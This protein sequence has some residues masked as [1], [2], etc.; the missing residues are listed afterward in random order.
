MFSP[1]IRRSNVSSR[2]ERNQGHT[3]LHSPI[4]PLSENR[5]SFLQNSVP[6][7]PSTGTPAPWAPRLS[8]LARIPPVNRSETGDEADP[9][10]P[11]YVGEFPQVIRDE[12]AS[13]LQKRVPDDA[14]ISGG[15]EKGTS[16]AWI[17]IGNRLFIW[18]YLSPTASMKCVVLEIPL[19]ALEN[20]DIN[21]TDR[22]C[23]L[24]CVV[25]W[26]S[27]SRRTKKVAKHC[28]S[29]GV[30]LCNQ[31][32]R[33]IIYWPEVY[34]EGRTAPVTSFASSEELEVTS[35]HENGKATP[36]KQRQRIR[37]GNNS[38]GWSS[39]NSLMASALP[40]SQHSCVALACCSNGEL[41]QFHCSPT[42][43]HRKKIYEDKLTLP[44]Q[45]SDGGQILW[46]KGYPRSLIWRFSHVSTEGSNREFFLLTDREIQCF[47]IDM[48]L[49]IR[50]SKLWSHE[51]IGTDGDAGIRK[52]LAGQKRIWPLDLQVD[53]HGKVITILVATFCKDRVSGS[54]YTQ[55]SLL[56]MQYKSGVSMEPAHERIL[57][58]KAPI[59]V[60][61]PKARVEDEDFLFS[62]RLRIGGK[63][64][65]SA[66]IL[67]GD[68]TATVA[69]YYRNSTHLY[70]F[71]LPY[72][73]GKVLDASVLLSSDDGEE[74]PWVVL[75]EKAGIW[76]IPEK[77]VVLGGVEPPERSLS[78]KGSSNER[79]AQEETR[80]LTFLGNIAPR[81]ASSEA[82]DAGE[83]QTGAFTG[84]VRR[85]GPD[86]ESE[87]LLSHLFHDFLSSG[88]VD[89]SL[90]KLKSSGAFERDGETS[91]FARM[92]KSIVDTLAK[93]WTTTRGAEIL[94]MAV[95]STQLMDKQQKHKA[96]LQFLALSK[97][98][99]ELCSRQRY[100]LRIILEHGEK[101]AGMIQLRELQNVIG[102]KRSTGV[103]S[104]HPSAER[105]AL[106]DLIQLVGE[107]ARRNTV[108]LMDRDNAEVFYSKVSDLE[109]V[110]YCLDRHLDYVIS[111]EQPLWIQIQRACELSNAC[112]T[113]VREAM[114]YRNENNLWYPPP[115]GLT[116]WYCQPVVR[117]G[118][119][120]IASFML[121]LLNETSGVEL[122]V[123]SDLYTHLEVL[124]EVLLETY[125][126]AVTAKVERGEEHKGL[127]DEFWSRRDTL[128]DSL[129]Q[130]VQDFVDG[131]HQD[132]NRGFEEQKE[133]I[134]RKL[135]LHLLSI[136][137]QHECY[138]TLWR[139]CCDLNDAALLRNLMHESMGPNGG[140]SYFVFKELYE[141]RQV[142]K[143]L[144]LGE[145][146][147]EEL[148]IFLR[149]HQELLWLHEVFLNQ[150]SSASEILHVLALSC[151]QNS[152]SASEEQADLDSIDFKPKL[153]DRK[154]L[155]NLSK[156][157]AWA[158]TGKDADSETKLKRIEA[159]RKILKLQ[160]EIML[161]LPTDEEKQYVERQLLHPEDLIKLCLKG[162]NAKL[163]LCAFD[164]FAWTGSSFRKTHRNLM[165]ECWKNA[166]DQDDWSQIYQA[167]IAQGWS[168][169]ETLQNLRE[170]MLFL[171]SSRCYG[172]N[173]E[174]F[175]EGFAEVMLLRRENVEPFSRDPGASVETIL[176]QHKDFPEAGK[177]M[178]AAITLGGVQD[179]TRL[180]EGPSPME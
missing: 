138:R 75:T 161:L 10:K 68:G 122:S 109:E 60:I 79:S 71:D 47:S 27:T 15:M 113:I 3:V 178:L 6:D 36:N 132:L 16:L 120:S 169:E 168:D 74:G 38:T 148:S 117:N 124:T 147:P 67:S 92:S 73:A 105:R 125:A 104:S 34:S 126:G 162:Q 84:V 1:G 64:S 70:Q 93:H 54:S 88:Q 42:G 170:T 156:I 103:G 175:G 85:T 12:Q 145:E 119:W 76:A 53:D 25:N 7:R 101:L 50:V 26:E 49:D 111:I 32:T 133:E 173:A 160:E 24:L 28:N 146:F 180:E 35:S 149:Q 39:L 89:G 52:D 118:M 131:R 81:R 30:V 20:R 51:I 157:A 112:A 43:I 69:H 2:N 29:A 59:Q 163:S 153:V 21:S 96:F 110:F 123:K 115:E 102:E 86:E 44:S 97:C 154:R 95:V 48:K 134:R 129:Y 100:S 139:I 179:N 137:K 40:G 159:D 41:W 90:E 142:S 99:E 4:T 56:T 62:M 11:V 166:A 164:V 158:A 141:K 116:P 172:P 22:N 171:A 83:R 114:H 91:V 18:N 150:F 5:R 121:Q 106:W 23:W 107:R 33:T 151:D 9:I 176:M 45:G 55:Y 17:I 65:G 19:N 37:C 63:P 143:V 87:T 130:Q 152:I 144:R 58:K 140:F 94:A 66:I 174:T 82:W 136:A 155:L 77:A 57:E 61:I 127:L 46:S 167:S 98:H 78:R 14:F 8:V 165:E 135:S 108:L 80:N 31:N 72:D 13:L 128:L 177:L